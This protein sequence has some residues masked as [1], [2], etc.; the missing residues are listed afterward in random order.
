MRHHKIKSLNNAMVIMVSLI[1]FFCLPSIGYSQKNDIN[2]VNQLI[3]KLKDEEWE[4]RDRAVNALVK[5]GT[6][7][8]EP[9]IAS[10][11]DKN[12]DV[13]QGAAEA[14]GEIKDTRAVEPLIALLKDIDEDVRYAAAKAL[15]EIKDTRA[16]EPLITALKDEDSN[17]R[18][19]V[20]DALGEIRD[21]RAVEPLITALKDED[22]KVKLSAIVALDIIG[23]EKAKSA[24]N[25]LSKGRNLEA[26]AKDYKSLIKKGEKGTEWL[27][28]LAL[29][30]HGNKDMANDFLNSRNFLL[31]EA[32]GL[33]GS[34]HG[35][36][37]I[38]YGPGVPVPDE[39]RK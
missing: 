17:V 18:R 9:L 8:V 31:N 16:V 26:I 22:S 12:E 39:G 10:L 30:K 13:R 32:A 27:L 5:I 35:L 4:V 34:K 23:N 28:I 14:L 33:W 2:K 36:V 29:L 21:T 7:S 15:G 1:V 38:Q 37:I 11:K 25:L 6:S 24:L 20:A 19:G 3:Q